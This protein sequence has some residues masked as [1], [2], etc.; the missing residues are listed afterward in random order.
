MVF[1][2]HLSLASTNGDT[3]YYSNELK[4]VK[5]EKDWSFYRVENEHKGKDTVYFYSPSNEIALKQV[6]RCHRFNGTQIRYHKNGAVARLGYFK[7]HK[8]V[9]LTTYYGPDHVWLRS[10]Y[11]NERGV[12]K[13]VFYK[14]DYP[15]TLIAECKNHAYFGNSK[16]IQHSFVAVSNYIS[17]NFEGSQLLD[18]LIDVFLT[19]HF[20]ISAE[21][22]IENVEIIRA[23]HPQ[24]DMEIKTIVERMPAWKPAYFKGKA[25]ASEFSITVNL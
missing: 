11:Y 12:K 9:R 10:E 20:Y 15:D 14:G 1:L 5:I 4:R 2:T 23:L 24:I 3:V 21:G 18:D 22:K 16:S 8:P 25:W 19:L 6:V 13:A 7:Y 17:A